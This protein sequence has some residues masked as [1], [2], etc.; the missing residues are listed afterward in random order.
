MNKKISFLLNRAS[1]Q[2]KLSE[3]VFYSNVSV[4]L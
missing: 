3:K 1:E 4:F 2:V